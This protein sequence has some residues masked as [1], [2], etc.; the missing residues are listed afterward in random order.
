PTGQLA[1]VLLYH[2][3]IG[4]YTSTSLVN[5]QQLIM[6]NGQRTTITKD[7]EGVKINGILITMA[8]IIGEN[9]VV[10]VIN[11]VILPD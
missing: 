10:H 1:T 11:A 5:G 7:D 4:T 3:S 9:G 8:D 2:V 6:A